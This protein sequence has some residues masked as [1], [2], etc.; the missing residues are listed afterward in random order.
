VVGLDSSGHAPVRP[1]R[2]NDVRVYRP[3]HKIAWLSHAPGV[4]FK[5]ADEPFTDQA[6]LIFWIRDPTQIL[7]KLN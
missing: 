7:K 5:M 6:P 2:L 1:T 4:L 3:L